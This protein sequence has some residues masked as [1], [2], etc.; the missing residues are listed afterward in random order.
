MKKL[1]LVLLALFF[2]SSLYAIDVDDQAINFKVQDLNGKT[3]ELDSFKG[4]KAVWLV[5]WATW[6]PNCKDEIPALKELHKKYNDKLEIIAVNVDV[7]DSIKRTK[8][9]IDKYELPYRVVYSNDI[10]RKYNIMGT[11]TQ[12]AIDINGKVVFVGVNIPHDLAEDDIDGLL[13]K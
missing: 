10:A 11:P 2:T 9:Y 7:N 4:K 6:C 8:K 3:V 5:F 13:K 12:V 1:F